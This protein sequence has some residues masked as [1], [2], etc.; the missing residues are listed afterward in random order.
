MATPKPSVT[1]C[2]KLCCRSVFWTAYTSGFFFSFFCL[3]VSLIE[4]ATAPG[5]HLFPFRTEKLSPV[6]P[7]VLRNSGR[8][9]RRRFL[10]KSPATV[11]LRGTFCLCPWSF[12]CLPVTERSA[13][14]PCRLSCFLILRFLGSLHHASLGPYTTLSWVL[15]PRFLRLSNR[16]FLS[17]RDKF[18]FF[19]KKFSFFFVHSLPFTTFAVYY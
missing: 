17:C 15:I 6:A 4:A 13:T 10:R 3:H 1:N 5:F 11:V 18:A 9:G 7:M 12:L 2:P 14:L 8:V 19:A 16:L